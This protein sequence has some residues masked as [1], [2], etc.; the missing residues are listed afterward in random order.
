LK[1]INDREDNP[2]ADAKAEVEN[3]YD[4]VALRHSRSLDFGSDDAG[5]RTMG[6]RLEHGNSY[7][8]AISRFSAGTGF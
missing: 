7:A 6:E 1:A 3:R 4:S 5:A 8:A 2:W